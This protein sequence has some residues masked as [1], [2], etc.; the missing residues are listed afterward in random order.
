MLL[1]LDRARYSEIYYNAGTP[2]AAAG[3]RR[4]RGSEAENGREHLCNMVVVVRSARE[5]DELTN[6]IVVIRRIKIN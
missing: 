6:N 4:V 1:V 5:W 3:G 2:V